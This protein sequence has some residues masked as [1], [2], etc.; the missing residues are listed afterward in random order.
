M[1]TRFTEQQLADP[2]I[3]QADSILRSCVHC[4]FCTA[5]CPTYILTGDERD[6]PRGRIYM[7]KEM[8]EDGGP[9]AADTATHIDRCLSCL[10]CMT[11]CP[12]GVDYMHLVDLGRRHM[13]DTGTRPLGERLL[14]GLLARVL[15][16]PARF[17]R[18]LRLARLARPFAPLMP[19]RLRAMLAL[20]PSAPDRERET[21]P[22]VYPARGI[23][24][25]RVA[26]LAGCV[27][28]AL[29]PRINAA[30]VS[31]LTRHGCE[32]VVAGGAGCCGAVA[33]HMGREADSGEHVRANVAAW[34][35]EIEDGGLDAIVVNASGCGTMVKDYGHILR[36][37]PEWAGRAKRVSALARDVSEF[38][39]GLELMN[40][41]RGPGLT[42]A[43][44][45]ACSLRHG[46]GVDAG[47]RMLLASCGFDVR[48]PADGH[49]CC[50]SAGTYN[51][52]QPEFADRL[53][54]RKAASLDALGADV[55]ASGNIGCM[56]QLAG[57]IDVPVVHTVELLDWA[58]G[59]GRPAAL[60]VAGK[61]E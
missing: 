11:T 14:R 10:G 44:Q 59:G 20:A 34:E 19:G 25:K 7:I 60:A 12:S 32:V 40:P 43:Y 51:I 26:L 33:H 4:G 53:R 1:Q 57:A 2:D 30:T 41:A 61:G 3:R 36:N 22:G 50:G 37:E 45:S 5:T 42:V 17:R 18:A 58:T 9:A 29:A 47:P 6:G 49:L 31:L 27:Q 13:E 46:Q 39:A 48:V 8:L 55:V 54:D 15:P 23:R 21:G 16:H 28:Q 24:R 56:T 38:V 35:R 52:L